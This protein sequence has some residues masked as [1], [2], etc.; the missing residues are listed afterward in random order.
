MPKI[1]MYALWLALFI[2]VLFLHRYDEY[3]V[4]YWC[5][6]SDG[7]GPGALTCKTHGAPT[8]KAFEDAI[9]EDLD[10][11]IAQVHGWQRTNYGWD[12]KPFWKQGKTTEGK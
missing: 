10:V 6:G 12:W 7:S 3:L 8:K 5:K 11:E 1:Y 9:L 2:H 4:S